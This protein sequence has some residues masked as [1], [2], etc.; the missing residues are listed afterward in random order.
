[1]HPSSMQEV[2]HFAV[3]TEESYVSSSRIKVVTRSYTSFRVFP[4]GR[5]LFTLIELA[6]LNY[7]I[8]Q[9]DVIY[10]FKTERAAGDH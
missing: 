2:S 4:K 10:V 7:L 1:M 9:G 5:F 3:P 6:I 8:L